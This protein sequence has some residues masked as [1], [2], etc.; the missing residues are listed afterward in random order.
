MTQAAVSYQIK[1]L[2]DRVGVP[3]FRRKARGVVLTPDGVRLAE[4]AGEA[5]EILRQ[6][7]A[8]ARHA[9]DDTLV[10]GLVATVAMIVRTS[11]EDA[12]L[13]AELPGYETYSRQVRFRL[14]PG[15]W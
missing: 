5:L 6:A 4:R 10:P 9:S 14:V 15:L 11:L 2:E 7:F 8:E 12:M 1:L 13:R 3:L